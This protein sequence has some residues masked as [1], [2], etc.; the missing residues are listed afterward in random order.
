MSPGYVVVATAGLISATLATSPP[1]PTW[2]YK[3]WTINGT[4]TINVRFFATVTGVLM[5]NTAHVITWHILRN[6]GSVASESQA[7]SGHLKYLGTSQEVL[8]AS[9][10]VVPGDVITPAI[11][12]TPAIPLFRTPQG[13]GQAGERFEITGASLT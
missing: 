12:H 13:T 2:P 9:I 1:N 8:G 3:G 10:A 6:G 7:V 4:G 11:F 5:D